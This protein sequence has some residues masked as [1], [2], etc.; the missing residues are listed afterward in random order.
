MNSYKKIW[1]SSPHMSGEELKYIQEA[2]D[3]NWIAPLG[4]HVDA[5]ENE[6]AN[7]VGVD[8]AA[9]LTSGTAAIHLA[10]VMLGV[11][12]GDDV[13][14]QSFTFS[15]SAN[16]IVY[17]HATPVFIDSETDTWN[18]D[19]DLLETAIKDRIKKGRK[20]KAV[21][22]VHLYGQPAKLDEI[23]QVC[24]RYEIPLIEDA[25]EALGSEYKGKKA[26]GFGK[27]GI[28]SFNGNKIITT[29]GGGML[30]SND[31][32]MIQKARFLSTQARD[33]A[34]HYEHSQI[35][36]N[37]RMSNVLAAIGRGQM[38]VLSERVK[39]RRAVYE[40][41]KNRLGDLPG[42]CF[43]PEYIGTFSNRWLTALTLDPHLSKIDREKIRLELAKKNIESRP[44]WKPMHLQPVFKD[45]PVYLNGT[46]ELLFKNGLCLP[47]GSNLTI[48]E[49][50][51]IVSTITQIF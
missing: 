36:Y 38:S 24:N 23:L 37:Y 50:E 17:Q 46:S 33:D 22:I 29:S 4:P 10:L 19:P 2:F 44:L 34:P 30:I 32:D 20:P 1:L 41:Y 31:K 49:L 40:F 9:A 7:F 15:A 12:P 43:Q 47:S 28:L 48:K 5:F 13:I 8:H 25:A 26:G 3:T 6:V 21:I 11:G 39:Q 27:F 14:C 45:A 42:L 35:G 51:L 16:P 18:M